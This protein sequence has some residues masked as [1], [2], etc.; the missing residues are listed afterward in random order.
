MLY[1]LHEIMRDIVTGFNDTTKGR[2]AVC[3]E[4]F[5]GAAE[6]EQPEEDEPSPD[7]EGF[8]SRVDLV[9]IDK[10]FHRFHLLCVH[11]DWF[12]QR[13]AEKDQHG[14]TITYKLP[15]I[16]KCPI[17]RREVEQEEIDYV[18]SQIQVHPEI[19]DGG[20]KSI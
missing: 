10:C 11:R 12:M 7:G 4:N 15:E 16:K 3:L 2:C 18:Q 5:N 9:R 20:Y 13:K 19:E 1:E 17:C 14:D 8:S 6:E